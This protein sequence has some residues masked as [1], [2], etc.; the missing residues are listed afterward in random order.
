MKL[1]TEY[2]CMDTKGVH[3]VYR[4]FT[5]HYLVIAPGTLVNISIMIAKNTTFIG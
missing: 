5:E 3:K 2:K 4:K 1:L